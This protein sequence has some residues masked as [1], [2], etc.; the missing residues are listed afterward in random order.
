MT[1]QPLE[2]TKCVHYRIGSLEKRI[3]SS[4]VES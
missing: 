4:E 1:K 3:E 2:I